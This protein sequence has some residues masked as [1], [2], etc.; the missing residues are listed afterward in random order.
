MARIDTLEHFL[1]DV[2]DSIKNKTGSS[3]A[4]ACKDFDTEIESID[5]GTSTY[6]VPLILNGVVQSQYNYIKVTGS[7]DGIGT[8]T[9]NYNGNG[10]A[11][12][13]AGLWSAYRLSFDK[14]PL[15]A[16]SKVVL[17]YKRDPVWTGY[18][19]SYAAFKYGVTNNGVDTETDILTG[20]QSQTTLT[21]LNIN[22]DNDCDDFFL[23]FV[24]LSDTNDYE[25]YGVSIYNLWVEINNS[26]MLLQNKGVKVTSNGYTTVLP[27][28][29]YVGLSG[30]TINSSVSS[31]PV[32]SVG[33]QVVG[34]WTNNKP[35]Y[36]K[37]LTGN[38][39]SGSSGEFDKTISADISE[40]LDIL[41]IG[42]NSVLIGS[43]DVSYPVNYVTVPSNNT[44]YLIKTVPSTINK[45][46]RTFSYGG[47]FSDSESISYSINIFYTKSSDSAVTNPTLFGGRNYSE[48]E[49]IIQDDGINPII[50][51]KTIT[52][53]T[54]GYRNYYPVNKTLAHNINNVDKIWISEGSYCYS[55][56]QSAK[57]MFPVQYLNYYQDL[58]RQHLHAT[59]DKTNLKLY[60]GD[61][62]ITQ[63]T[64]YHNVTLRYTKV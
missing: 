17:E 5:G 62:V 20:T 4:I 30:V 21:T 28:Q 3:N 7:S 34:T 64:I 8:F 32:I 43:D 47:V 27:D 14:L 19:S 12:G 46:V 41:F 18:N 24:N 61:W 44:I 59:V 6:K 31:C 60:V 58:Y 39:T 52:T 25:K 1:T 56:G 45:S 37:T 38:I 40:S 23:S 49:H 48:T 2:A 10:F 54:S 9:E 53:T 22:I 36:M 13:T 51:E 15:K 55:G 63:G 57:Q 35:L 29:G 26:S 11:F 33:E 50:Y 42:E 16:G